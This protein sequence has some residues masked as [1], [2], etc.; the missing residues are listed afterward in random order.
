VEFRYERDQS[1]VVVRAGGLEAT[2]RLH[3]IDLPLYSGPQPESAWRKPV[4]G[5][6]ARPFAEFQVVDGL[7]ADGWT[8]A[9]VNRPGKFLSGWEPREVAALPPEALELH[10]MIRDDG[11][12]RAGCWDVFAWREGRCLFAEL[13]RGRSSDRIRESQ[14]LWRESALRL[15][16]PSDAFAIVEWFGGVSS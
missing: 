12:N 9:W 10:D 2:V 15:G 16:V 7:E 14:L 5:P 6:P 13:K 3:R 8:A 4:V 1:D 11:Q